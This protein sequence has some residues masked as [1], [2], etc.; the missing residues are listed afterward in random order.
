MCHTEPETDRMAILDGPRLEL[1][2]GCHTATSHQIDADCSFCHVPLAES[3]FGIAE[4]ESI[5]MPADHAD[6]SFLLEAHGELAGATIARCATCHTQDRCAACH[7]DTDRPE[8]QALAPAPEGMEL[9]LLVSRY[10]KPPTHEDV[11][12]WLE[13]HGSEAAREACATCHTQN[14]CRSCHIAPVPPVLE[15][16]PARE[17]VVAPGVGVMPH[18]PSSHGSVFFLDVHSGL[19]AS[20]A[21]YCGTCHDDSFCVSCHAGP[22]DG[23]YHPAGFVAQHSA[24]AFG[25]NAECANCHSSE[26][27]CR[28]CH[29][30]SG[31]TGFGRLGPGYHNAGAFWVIRHGQAARQGLESCISCHEQTDCTQ[32]HGVAGAFKVSPHS[33]DFDPER[34]W[35]RSPRTCI[36]CHLSNPLIGRG[37]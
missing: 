36:A 26:A 16:L 19:A 6:P 22:S 5:S 4:I 25:R 11:D 2:W 34:A 24:Y 13:T 3:G 29:A 14:D 8:I 28:E 7:V 33:S 12:E 18:P 30:Q 31:L 17:Q 32:C 9:P 20:D 35:E 1:C 15:T 23:G 10:E 21:G 27:F 37:P